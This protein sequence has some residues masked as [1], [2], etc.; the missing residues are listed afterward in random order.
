MFKIGQ[1]VKY[2]KDFCREEE[3]ELIH[4]IKEIR[5]NPV[6]GKETR[7][8]IETINGTKYLFSMNPVEVVDD[9]MVEEL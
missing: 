9:Y 4:V 8:L 2:K 6:T 7:F 5:L 1:K 3:R